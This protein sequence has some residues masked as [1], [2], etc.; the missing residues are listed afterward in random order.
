MLIVWLFLMMSLLL[1]LADV[2]IAGF[3]FIS[4][5]EALRDYRDSVPSIPHHLTLPIR[6]VSPIGRQLATHDGRWLSDQCEGLLRRSR[7]RG[8]L[9]CSGNNLSPKYYTFDNKLY[10]VT[11]GAMDRC[12]V[13]PILAR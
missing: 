5:Y 11:D 12:C 7:D 4:A 2:A 9:R 10:L 6:P 1:P 13:T 8:P 3:R